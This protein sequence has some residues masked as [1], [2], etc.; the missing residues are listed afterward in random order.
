LSTLA[1]LLVAAVVSSQ[2]RILLPET[3]GYGYPRGTDKGNYTCLEYCVYQHASK[4]LVLKA[5]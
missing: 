5:K 3:R 2:S 1:L 4:R